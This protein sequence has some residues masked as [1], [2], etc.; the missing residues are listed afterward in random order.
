EPQ[1]GRYLG[2]ASCILAPSCGIPAGHWGKGMCATAS[3]CSAAE[4]SP[5]LHLPV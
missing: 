1:L 5:A 3:W 4:R 2:S